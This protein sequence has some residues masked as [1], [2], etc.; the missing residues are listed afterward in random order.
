MNCKNCAR[1]YLC[2]KKECKYIPYSKIKDYGEIRKE[3]KI[4]QN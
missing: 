3:K 2:N 1:Q 4:C